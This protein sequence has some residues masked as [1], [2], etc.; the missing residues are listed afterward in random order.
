MGIHF[1]FPMMWGHMWCRPGGTAQLPQSLV[2]SGKHPPCS[3]AAHAR[4]SQQEPP[5]PLTPAAP[6]LQND[7]PGGHIVRHR[8]LVVARAAAHQH[9]P[10][11]LCIGER[12]AT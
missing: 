2:P 5:A 4:T 9:P 6:D 1:F 3:Q 12:R 8:R 11:G 7:V 10:G